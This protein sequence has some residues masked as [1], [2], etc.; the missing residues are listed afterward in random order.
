MVARSKKQISKDRALRKRILKEKARLRARKAV[1]K[2]YKKSSPVYRVRVKL[3]LETREK[4]YR[5]C[6]INNKKPYKVI[7]EV[8]RSMML[9]DESKLLGGKNGI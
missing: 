6:V 4:L 5:Y 3:N 8:L 7:R 1:K 9:E 2:V